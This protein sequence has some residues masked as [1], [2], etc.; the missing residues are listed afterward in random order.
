MGRL[1][2]HINSAY[3]EFGREIIRER[4]KA[5]IK[6]KREKTGTWG[7]KALANELRQK[8]KDMIAAKQTIRTVARACAGGSYSSQTI[9]A[10][11]SPLSRVG[12]HS[13]ARRYTYFLNWPQVEP[14][15][16]PAL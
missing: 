7:R 2:F 13:I 15:T 5:G 16:V 9:C 1:L 11:S 6:A 10:G 12:P 4:V 8:I 14:A 3:A